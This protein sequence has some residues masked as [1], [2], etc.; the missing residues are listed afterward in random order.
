ML[1][2][3]PLALCRHDPEARAFFF[4]LALGAAS[5]LAGEP[6]AVL[7]VFCEDSE[8]AL[9]TSLAT[10]PSASES[11]SR[12]FRLVPPMIKSC[13][14]TDAS[15]K[16]RLTSNKTFGPA[17]DHRPLHVCLDV[18]LKSYLKICTAFMYTI[19]HIM[20]CV[21]C[22]ALLCFWLVHFTWLAAL[23][24]RGTVQRNMGQELTAGGRG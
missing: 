8:A 3:V 6:L 22:P 18:H 2:G 24:W 10:A 1:P 16:G 17:G 5:L 23:L 13:A 12:T 19:D 9:S 11:I 21:L 14:N 7:H 15:R 20:C 4:P